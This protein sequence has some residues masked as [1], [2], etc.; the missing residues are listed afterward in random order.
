MNS[1]ERVVVAQQSVNNYQKIGPTEWK[2]GDFRIYWLPPSAPHWY[3]KVNIKTNEH[4]FFDRLDDA[5][6]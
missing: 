2:F 6:K 4:W 1:Q 3:L 5:T